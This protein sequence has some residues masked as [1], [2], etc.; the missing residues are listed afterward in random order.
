[1][2]KG[3]ICVLVCMLM[4][5]STIVPVS[6]TTV[7]KKTS[8]PLTRGN[9]LYVGG[10]GPNNYTKIQDA[11]DNA[12]SG[13]TVFVYDDSSP[14]KENIT[15]TKS[16]TI[17]GENK[18]TTIIDGSHG[19]GQ[20][21][22]ITS[23]NVTITSFTIQNTGIAVYIGGVGGTASHNIVTNTIILN[24]SVGVVMFY[25]D[26][27][28]ADFSSYGYN[29]ISDNYI[30]N[31][32]YEGI[33]VNQ[34]QKNLITRNTITENHGSDEK[35][36]P[37]FGIEVS[38]AF[39]NI[40]YNNVSDNNG[41]GIIIGDTYKTIVYRNNI[42]NNGWYGL[43]IACGSFDRIIQNNFIGNRKSAVYD[44]QIKIFFLNVAKHYP[45][46]PCIW[47]DNYWNRPR[48]LPYIIP[49][50]IGY[51]GL[52]SWS[53]Y[54]KFDIIPTNFIRFDLHPAQEPY[55]VSPGG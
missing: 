36:H 8:Q 39:N 40:S 50:S 32:T 19:I 17:Q 28:I 12:S 48:L 2:K 16:L 30:K 3:I 44:Q 14:Y 6:G 33:V 1:M 35:G 25:G 22:S 37:G 15:I 13:D 54:A 43:G 45:I 38:G 26:P 18:Y 51:M 31:T 42:E 55:D 52:I 11:V 9:I 46:L 24:A 27:M 47:R 10:S 49:G 53:F 20:S 41:Y 4:I 21:F 5:L 34:G 29:T 7:S 23:D